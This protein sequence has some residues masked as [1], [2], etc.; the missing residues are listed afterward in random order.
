[1]VNDA[2]EILLLTAVFV[3]MSNV[4]IVSED[5]YMAPAHACEFTI[6][7]VVLGWDGCALFTSDAFRKMVFA[8]AVNATY[9]CMKA[10]MD[11]AGMADAEHMSDDELLAAFDTLSAECR[12]EGAIPTA[13]ELVDAWEGHE[14]EAVLA[15]VK[16]YRYDWTAHHAAVMEEMGRVLWSLV[17]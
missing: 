7:R 5:T 2:T 17:P 9:D 8:H 6:S 1:M 12:D 16:A 3:F 14:K 15:K 11:D 10:T 13:E 4:I